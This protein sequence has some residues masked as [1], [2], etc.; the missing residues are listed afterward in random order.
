MASL[1]SKCTSTDA[2]EISQNSIQAATKAARTKATIVASLLSDRR[3]TTPRTRRSARAAGPRSSPPF[4][5]RPAKDI[6]ALKRSLGHEL[7]PRHGEL[8]GFP[9]SGEASS[10]G[11]GTEQ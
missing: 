9:K 1:A 11:L 6:V 10:L 5:S 3:R 4:A 8:G 7:P 2:V